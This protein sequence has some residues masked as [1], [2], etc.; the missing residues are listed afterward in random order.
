MGE[1]IPIILRDLEGLIPD[2]VVEVLRGQNRL[3]TPSPGD[4]SRDREVINGSFMGERGHTGRTG[5]QKTVEIRVKK[6]DEGIM[7]RNPVKFFE[8]ME[9]RARPTRA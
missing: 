8:M 6:K 7:V 9:K 2:A 3:E 4:F 1:I 5:V